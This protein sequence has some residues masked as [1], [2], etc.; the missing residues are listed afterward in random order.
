MFS[1]T[2]LYNFAVVTNPA[3]LPKMPKVLY[4]PTPLLKRGWVPTYTV[5]PG[6]ITHL[7]S[8]KMNQDSTGVLVKIHKSNGF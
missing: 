6:S 7:V 3:A 2:V 4:I 8:I 1:R 5:A